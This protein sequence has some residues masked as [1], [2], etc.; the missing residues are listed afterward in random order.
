M[1]GAGQRSS[2]RPTEVP[3]LDDVSLTERVRM[4]RV[5]VL[6]EDIRKEPLISGG[7]VTPL[8]DIRALPAVGT[9][10]PAT[11][12]IGGGAE[13]LDDTAVIIVEETA[14]LV[15]PVIVDIPSF[16]SPPIKRIRLEKRD[17]G[18]GMDDTSSPS[19][20]RDN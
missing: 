12:V 9:V 6:L 5:R 8:A 10:P 15:A 2:A 13:P 14:A 1:R 7:Q 3:Y 18:V 20:S 4:T 16:S 11:T 17:S 19:T